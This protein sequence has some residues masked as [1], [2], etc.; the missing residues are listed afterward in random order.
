MQKLQHGVQKL[1]HETEQGFCEVNKRLDAYEA[2][3]ATAAAK[4]CY[5]GLL[6]YHKR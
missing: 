1:E 3:V 6:G 2:A 4:P 5:T